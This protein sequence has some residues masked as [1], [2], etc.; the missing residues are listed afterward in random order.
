MSKYYCDNYQK[1]IKQKVA[2][3]LRTFI[4]KN[5]SKSG[6][7]GLRIIYLPKQM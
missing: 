5:Y 1:C 3:D 6:I 7:I 2:L 4:S